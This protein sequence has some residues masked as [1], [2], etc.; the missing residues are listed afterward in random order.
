MTNA[1]KTLEYGR[2]ILRGRGINFTHFKRIVHELLIVKGRGFDEDEWVELY[3]DCAVFT[4]SYNKE[5]VK[6]WV[7]I[8]FHSHSL[9]EVGVELNKSK[10]NK[11]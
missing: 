3:N 10:Y 2:S 9:E 1:E 4:V 5:S 7:E 11:E 6:D 8:Y